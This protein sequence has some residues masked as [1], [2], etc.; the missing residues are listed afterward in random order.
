MIK[1][2][3]QVFRQAT[4]ISKASGLEL[5]IP[6]AKFSWTSNEKHSGLMVLDYLFSLPKENIIGYA[7][8]S[9]Y[10]H[11]LIVNQCFCT[12]NYRDPEKKLIKTI[13]ILINDCWLYNNTLLSNS[14]INID[15]VI[16]DSEFEISTNIKKQ[17]IQLQEKTG[18]LMYKLGNII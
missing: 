11:H 2:E 9:Y 12:I 4:L 1:L 8:T 3:N 15:K 6:E 5:Y 13:A 17:I 14:Q 10:K 7:S 18:D 16:K